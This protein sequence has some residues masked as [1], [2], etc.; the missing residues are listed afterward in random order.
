MINNNLNKNVF[1]SEYGEVYGKKK[2][3]VKYG[4]L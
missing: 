2:Y 4:Y 3:W 1:L